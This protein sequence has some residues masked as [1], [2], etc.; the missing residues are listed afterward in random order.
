M[1][2]LFFSPPRD[3]SAVTLREMRD[4]IAMRARGAAA[5]VPCHWVHGANEIRGIG[6]DEGT[7]YCRPCCEKAV[8]KIRKSHP[9]EA[10]DVN[11][12]VDGG[13]STD[14][15]SPPYCETCGVPLDGDLTDCGV[16][17]EIQALTTYA[18]P[19]TPDCWAQLDDAMINVRGEDMTLAEYVAQP[20]PKDPL[21]AKIHPT[22]VGIW[23]RVAPVV[24]A[25]MAWKGG[26]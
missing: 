11:I 5:R 25:D 22:E 19:T 15:D 13:W 23:K 8:R 6:C 10:R 18:I 3:W 2:S 24:I 7:N 20:M 16:E 9:K 17:E 4:H 12:C 21:D 1:G 26:A 14:H